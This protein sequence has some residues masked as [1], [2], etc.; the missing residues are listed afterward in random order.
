MTE[1]NNEINRIHERALRIT[2]KDMTSDFDTMLL[3]D[4]AVPIHIRNLQLLMTE[5]YKTK[6]ELSP[7]VMVSPRIIFY[8]TREG[9]FTA[10][11]ITLRRTENSYWY[12]FQFEEPFCCLDNRTFCDCWLE[13][14]RGG[15]P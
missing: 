9:Q 6:W 7:S 1:K 2:Y 12:C 3:K 10:P 8:W 11:L 5:V 14:E 15:A 13:P 4:N